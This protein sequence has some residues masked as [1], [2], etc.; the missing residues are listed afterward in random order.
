MWTAA[1][2]IGDGDLTPMAAVAGTIAA[3]TADFLEHLGMTRV[4][5]NNGGDLALRLKGEEKL[6]IG[7]R[8]RV[9]P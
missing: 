5:V 9:D 2:R 1:K 7:I 3:A 6:Y 4:V 8:P